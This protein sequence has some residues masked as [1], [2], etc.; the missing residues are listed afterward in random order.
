MNALRTKT[1]FHVEMDAFFVSVEEL[2][3]P[4]LKGKAQPHKQRFF[5]GCLYG[6]IR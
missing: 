1:I 3:D 6:E 2:S 5:L 4:S